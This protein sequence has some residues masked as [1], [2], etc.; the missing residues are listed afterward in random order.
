[1]PDQTSVE[2]TF[3]FIV[4]GGGAAGCV[5]AEKLSRHFSCLLLEAGGED[6]DPTIELHDQW[7]TCAT[8]AE[9]T[10]ALPTVPQP[11]LDARQLHP[12]MGRVVGGSTSINA[13]YWV[14]GN[15]LDFDRW[16]TIHHCSGWNADR[17]LQAYKALEKTGDGDDKF[18]GR[19]GHIEV[20]LAAENPAFHSFAEACKHV[21]VPFTSDSNSDKQ[22][23]YSLLWN[24]VTKDWRRHSAFRAFVHP[25]LGRARLTLK[26]NATVSRVLFDADRRAG[27]VECIG[28]AGET[29]TARARKEVILCAGALKTPQL[30]ML[31]GIGDSDHLQSIGINPLVRLPGVGL[32]LRDHLVTVLMFSGKK[33]L[34]STREWSTWQ[35]LGPANLNW[36]ENQR[37]DFQI[38]W[39]VRREF[40][41]GFPKPPGYEDSDRVI[42]TAIAVLHPHAQGSVRLASADPAAAPVINPNYLGDDPDMVIWR[43]AFTLLR[44]LMSAPGMAEWVEAEIGDCPRGMELEDYVRKNS[45]SQWHPVGTCRMSSR[46]DFLSVVDDRCRVS[47]VTALRVID[48]S[49]MPEH[50]SGNTQ[51]PTMAVAEIASNM[52]VEDN[53]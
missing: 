31:S 40:L 49:V 33:E 46:P 32:H 30:L 13:M 9:L 18:H 16:E 45:I 39:I 26:T 27:A 50:P 23:G 29:W 19:T 8:K 3:D 35:V 21:G 12:N 43:T 20:R 44:H 41:P 6:A 24:N 52:V 2:Q 48:A 42:A 11:R 15:L 53:T 34:P 25:H 1:M 37:A 28:S 51:A 7:F 4:V 38:Q 10:W 36:E 5:T 14:R 22:L 17:F 47:G